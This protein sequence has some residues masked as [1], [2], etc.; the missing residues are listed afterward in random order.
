[1]RKTLAGICAVSLAALAVAHCA[2]S[3]NGGIP[4]GG[5][6]ASQDSDGGDSDSGG[7]SDGGVGDDMRGNPYGTEP[8][9]TVVRI[10]TGIGALTNDA[11][12]AFLERHSISN[13]ALVGA[14]LA[15]PT[16]VSG[17]NKQLTLS[18]LATVEGQ[19]SRSA[20]G[21]YLVIAGYAAPPGAKDISTS[22][23]TTYN[24]VIGRIDAF[25]NINTATAT[26]AYSGSAVRGATSTDGTAMW[27]STDVGVG[28]TIVNATAP[29]TVLSTVI[30]RAIDVFG[31]GNARQLYVSSSSSSGSSYLGI[32]SVGSGTPTSTATV[33]RLPGFTDANNPSAVGF[34]GFDRDGNGSIDQLY[35][36]DDRTSGGGL[37][38]WRLNGST[39]MLEGTISTGIGSGARYA[40]GFV[41]GNTASVLV[42][43]SE[44]FG[45]APRILLLTDTGGSTAGVT[46]KLLTTAATNTT[47]RGIALAPHP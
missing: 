28:Y 40:A 39:W 30:T 23:A 19:L 33:S 37:Q 46:S 47:Y 15:L 14:P 20:D 29:P 4:T 3:E 21:R 2:S 31:T 13:G 36:A 27:I 6:L 45:I 22:S 26:T 38:R 8:E 44:G 24:R 11:T 10:G 1:M 9:F 41:F 17:A 18:G 12:V 34:V 16:A 5:D 42:T 32:N 25:N 7:S 35:V 43:T